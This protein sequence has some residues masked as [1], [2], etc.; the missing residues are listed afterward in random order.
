MNRL[1]ACIV[2][3]LC[4]FSAVPAQ[5]TRDERNAKI[6]DAARANGTELATQVSVRNSVTAQA[7]LIPRV[8]ARR[9]FGEEIANNYAIIEVNVSNKS[10]DAALIIHGIFIDYSKWALKGGPGFVATRGANLNADANTNPFQSST[11]INQV[12]S[13]E[14]RVVRGQLLDAQMWSK[15]NWT[16]RLLTLAGSLASAYS[17]SIGEEGIVRGLNAFSGS[18]VPG[19]REAW[20]DG[21]IEQLNRVSDFGFQTNKV[22]SKQG[23]EIIVCFFPIDRF[24][25]PGFKK[26][27][28]ENPALFF[29]PLQMLYDE[30]TAKRVRS[31]VGTTLG[32][33]ADFAA[34][35]RALPCYV[36]VDEGE[37]SVG[38]TECLAEL[39]LEERIE[40]NV[41]KLVP[42]AG[43]EAATRF[44]I[45]KAIDFINHVSLNSVTVTIDGVM[46]VD[47]STIA[48]NI[49]SVA[50]DKLKN[51]GD[52][53][54]PCFWSD[55]LVASGV[56]TGTIT[57]SYLTGGNV[58]IAEAS[59]LGI[60]EVNTISDASSDQKVNFSFKLTKSIPPNTTLHFIITK[61]KPGAADTNATTDSLPWEYRIGY[62]P[63]APTVTDVKQEGKTLTVKGTGFYN[64]PPDSALVVKLQPPIGDDVEVTPT[65]VSPTQL[66]LT[67]PDAAAPAGC[68]KVL[69]SMGAL[70]AHATTPDCLCFVVVPKPELESA[71]RQGDQI[72]VTGTDLIDTR[73]CGGPKLSFQLQKE[74]GTPIAAKLLGIDTL[75]RP[76]LS[77]G[78]AK[79]GSWTVLV[80]LGSEKQGDPVKLE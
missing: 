76:I 56:R 60:T 41:T 53:V 19:V 30:K 9:I 52:D 32:D 4:L 34:M 2:L 36:S 18:V 24:L 40:N 75:G 43:A 26:L 79:E 77:L 50:L 7:V 25:T 71:K 45:T 37:T 64:V 22:I 80:L 38:Y 70:G 1:T 68:W 58:E 65:S 67:I 63:I 51:C 12:A 16:M 66:V 15:R 54:N 28:K 29:A 5:T 59:D 6:L 11:R 35:R 46:S 3:A 13:E 73:A 23:G 47:T 55:P 31:V 17:F 62:T 42:R 49:D 72:I 69:V 8:D 10:S 48:A 20:P 74:G 33:E 57:G 27:F 39:G 78:N 44:K 14:Y 21:T 61:P